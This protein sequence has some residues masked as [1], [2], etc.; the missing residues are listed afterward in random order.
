MS[1]TTSVF[2]GNAAVAYAAFGLRDSYYPD[3]ARFV[4]DAARA[5]LGEEFDRIIDLGSGIGMSTMEVLKDT[6][7][8]GRV[9]AVEPEEAMRY[10]ELMAN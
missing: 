10:F 2:A 5:R 1:Q 8:R 6:N 9:I 3:M 7:S 4:I